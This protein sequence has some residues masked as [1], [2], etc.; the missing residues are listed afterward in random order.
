MLRRFEEPTPLGPAAA[1]RWEA[2]DAAQEAL[3]L[4]LAEV[5][6]EQSEARTSSGRQEWMDLFQPFLRV[7]F[8]V[9]EDS[10]LPG[11]QVLCVRA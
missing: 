2:M 5:D 9:L 11:Q 1:R 3:K 7:L 4:H 8:P 10:F 6:G